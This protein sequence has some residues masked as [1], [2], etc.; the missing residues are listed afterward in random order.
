TRASATAHSVARHTSVRPGIEAVVTVAPTRHRLPSDR[1]D[2]SNHAS[3]RANPAPAAQGCQGRPANAGANDACSGPVASLTC[4]SSLPS[5]PPRHD[6][7]H[8]AVARRIAPQAQAPPRHPRPTPPAHRLEPA[9]RP[10]HAAATAAHTRPQLAV[11]RV[12]LQELR[13]RRRL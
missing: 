6:S 3:V 13:Q 9:L 10:D 8:E 5:T 1:A 4:L 7:A 2:R 11:T 12:I